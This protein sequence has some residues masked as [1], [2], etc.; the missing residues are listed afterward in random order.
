MMFTKVR[1]R[2]EV[3]W[4]EIGSGEGTTKIPRS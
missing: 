3:D 1:G 4:H 2:E